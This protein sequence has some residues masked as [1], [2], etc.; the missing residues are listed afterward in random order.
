MKLAGD[1]PLKFGWV[2]DGRFAGRSGSTI[3]V[4]FPPSLESHTQTL[5]WPQAV[6][7]IEEKLSALLGEKISFTPRFTGEEP[8]PIPEP[9]PAAPAVAKS[10]SSSTG[11]TSSKTS[12]AQPTTAK[13]EQ[14]SSGLTHEE[15]EAFKADPLIKKAL[16][17]FKAEIL[18]SPINTKTT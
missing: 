8:T 13:L 2:E 15:M 1:S 11:S 4:E 5:F 14:P 7:K 16:E 12:A 18:A 9:E 6:K 3:T 17:I 10:S